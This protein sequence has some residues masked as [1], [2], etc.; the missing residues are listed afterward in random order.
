MADSRKYEQ[1]AKKIPIFNGLDS[2]QVSDI[3]HKG[4]SMRFKSG[5]TIFHEGQ[6]GSDL[7]IVFNGQVNISKNEQLIDRRRT[8]EAFGLNSTLNHVPHS[9]TAIAR[10]EVK[11][12]ALHE[13]ALT[14]I[15]DSRAGVRFLLNICRAVNDSRVNLL[16]QLVRTKELTTT[17]TEESY[18]LPSDL[19]GPRPGRIKLTL[20]DVLSPE[21][22][23]K[24]INALNR[25]HLNINGKTLVDPI[26]KVGLPDEIYAETYGLDYRG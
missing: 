25:L 19:G 11:L 16:H 23:T 21:E 5:D 15:F 9:A 1:Y 10:N 20:T 6:L 7:F 17:K 22:L 14:E 13:T 26:V 2:E 18:F 8:G 24:I 12:F 3:I 4:R